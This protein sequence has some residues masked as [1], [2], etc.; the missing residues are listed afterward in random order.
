[1]ISQKEIVFEVVSSLRSEGKS[2]SQILLEGPGLLLSRY[3]NGDWGKKS[4]GHSDE[5]VLRYS[6]DLIKNWTKKDLR[7]NGGEKYTP[8]TTPTPV[9]R[10]VN[11]TDQY[12][13][14]L[15]LL[16]DR[17][18]PN[19]SGLIQELEEKIMWAEHP[20]LKVG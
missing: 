17:N 7:L 6:R 20:S 1:M 11:L 4:G 13:S 19:D 2:D 16:R 14:M 10:Q 18:D 5:E 15:T 12:R 3:R 9:E 8:R